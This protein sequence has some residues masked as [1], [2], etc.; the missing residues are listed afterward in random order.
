MNGSRYNDYAQFLK[1]QFPHFKVQ[2]LSINAG[3]TC[4]NRDGS[5][6]R[7]GCTYCN[8]HSF[9]PAYTRIGSVSEQ[10]EEGR[11]F[12]RNKYPEMK[13][14]AYFQSY[15]N[16]YGVLPRLKALY[17]EALNT[18][19]VVGLI[20]G[21]R[22][23]CVSEELLDYFEALSKKTFL[24]IEYGVESTNDETLHRVNR[25]HT[26]AES[27]QMIEATA[28]RGIPV[29]AHLI[30]GLPGEA[31]ADFESHIHRLCQLPITSLKLHQLQIL[32]GTQMAKDY[33]NDPDSFPLFTP[34]AYAELVC[35]LLRF[36]PECIY[37]DRFVSQSP[38]DMLLAPKWGIK[39]YQFVQIVERMMATNDWHQ[40][41][42]I[43][44]NKVSQ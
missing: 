24:A 13:Y 31:V 39:N 30:M 33:K 14:L 36:I 11:Q 20:I 41:D 16:T 9:S 38:P 32:R 34:E 27:Q 5:K 8:N 4:P 6:G 37:V 42:L 29:G 25:G 3:F 2:K 15:T 23:D 35:H 17:E 7:G 10:I 26:F 22:P 43:H 44:E 28:E 19:D 21:T 40:G 18:P 1:E 12:F